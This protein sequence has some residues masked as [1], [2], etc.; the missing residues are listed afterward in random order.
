[1]DYSSKD[2]EAFDPRQCLASK[3]LKSQRIISNIFRSHLK[4]FGLSNSQMSVLFVMSKRRV[5]SQK[6]LSD[7]LFLEKS[8]TNRNLK[9]LIAQDYLIKTEKLKIKITE[10]GLHMVEKVIPA[11]EAAM[12]ETQMKLGPSGVAALDTFHQTLI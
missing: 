2:L 5:L 1:M 7:I 3:V 12:K 6:E 11:W 4:E 10:Y 9:R 8:S